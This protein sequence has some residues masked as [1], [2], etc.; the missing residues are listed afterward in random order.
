MI[1]LDPDRDGCTVWCVNSFSKENF[2][3]YIK[4]NCREVF[5]T[6]LPRI[7]THIV[8]RNQYGNTQKLLVLKDM[9]YIDNSSISVPYVDMFNNEGLYIETLSHRSS[10]NIFLDANMTNPFMVTYE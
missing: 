1:I 8:S 10:K 6:L 5:Y 9:V 4:G 3:T 7:T 2:V